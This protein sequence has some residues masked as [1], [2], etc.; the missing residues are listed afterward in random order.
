MVSNY[1]LVHQLVLSEIYFSLLYT[2][3]EAL[4][5]PVALHVNISE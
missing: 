5:G 1:E 4:I 3:Q 2:Q